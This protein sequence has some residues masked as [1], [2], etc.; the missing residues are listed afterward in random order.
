M[1]VMVRP[2]W[3]KDA[4]GESDP[5]GVVPG[6]PALIVAASIVDGFVDQRTVGVQAPSER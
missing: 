3:L 2:G 1:V 4:G 5:F 6:R